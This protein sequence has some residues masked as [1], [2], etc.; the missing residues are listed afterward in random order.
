M[1]TVRVMVVDD[2][3]DNRF[4]IRAILEECGKDLDVVAEAD[5]ARAALEAIA[6]VDPDVVVLDARMPRID[7]YE[8]AVL[9]RALRPRQRI[10]LWTAHVDAEVEARAAEAGVDRVVS[11]G[12][13]ARLP[14][15]VLE[16][17]GAR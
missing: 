7:G 12:D 14:D 16:L 4:L 2:G 9:I 1:G 3:A 10:L 11:K 8:A 15:V 5:S 13:F 17:A 6:G